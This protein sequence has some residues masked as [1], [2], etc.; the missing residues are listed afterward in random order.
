MSKIY[1]VHPISS[2]IPSKEE[3][4]KLA[5]KYLNTFLEKE[6]IKKNENY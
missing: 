6:N 4:G 2:S 1:E 3:I 5:E